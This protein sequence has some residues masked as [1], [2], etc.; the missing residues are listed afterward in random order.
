MLIGVLLLN[1]CQVS[2][3]RRSENPAVLAERAEALYAQA[4][5]PAAAQLWESLVLSAPGNAAEWQL[6]AADAWL[7]NNQPNIAARRLAELDQTSL[8]PAQLAHWQLLRTELALQQ[9]DRIA[10]GQLFERLTQQLDVLPP[11]LNERVARLNVQ[12]G[13]PRLLA[14]DAALAQL[15]SSATAQ[16]RQ[17]AFNELANLPGSLLAELETGATESERAYLA[18]IR[19]ARESALQQH[20]TLLKQPVQ[21]RQ[22]NP[23][24]PPDPALAQMTERYLQARRWPDTIA[25]LLP[26]S[27]QLTAAAQAIHQGIITGWLQVAE[28]QRPKLLFIDS[29][30]SNRDARGAYFS[31]VDSG[32]DWIIGP[33]RKGSVA[34]LIDLPNRSVPMLALNQPERSLDELSTPAREVATHYTFSLPP[35]DNARASARLAI[36]Q[37]HRNIIVLR[38]ESESGLRLSEAFATE[39]NAQGGQVLQT[40]VY[41]NDAIEY[42]DVLASAL[43]LNE[44]LQRHAQLQRRL[45]L[46]ELGFRQQGRSDAD[47]LFIAGNSAQARLIM[48]QLKFLDLD[49]LP[50]YA[51]RQ[52]YDGTPNIRRDRDLNGIYFTQQ[53]WLAGQPPQPLISTVNKWFPDSRNALLAELFGLGRDS[54]LLLPYLNMLQGETEVSLQAA[55]GQLQISSSGDVARDLQAMRFRS[56]RPI[57]LSDAPR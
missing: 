45:G 40:S 2:P 11:Q 3:E 36:Q 27:G 39:L 52:V 43:R 15:R 46:D 25:V 44:S 23:A 21:R 33:L 47:A 53:A 54:L 8:S 26:Q 5:Y 6:R 34:A 37:G 55:S 38:P 42:T 4:D 29:G 32:A 22:V 18:Q 31:A 16:A 13:D 28:T 51:T 9:G 24:P 10:A 19:Q 20:F 14:A 56:G 1:A 12:L 17:P 30:A 57:L 35:E 41:A 49:Y 7:L 48:P 50:V